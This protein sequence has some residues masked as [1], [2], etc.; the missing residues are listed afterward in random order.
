MDEK[1]KMMLGNLVG[2]ND[3]EIYVSSVEEAIRLLQLHMTPNGAKYRR[4]L[5]EYMT[6]EENE[7]FGECDVY[8]NF[9]M[10]LFRVGDYYLALLVCDFALELAPTNR[11][12]LADAI[13]ACRNSSQYERGEKYLSKAEE[14]DYSI[15][16]YRLFLYSIDFLQGKMNAFPSDMGIF[17][18]ADKLANEYIKKFPFDEHGY[19]QKAELLIMQNKR[20]EAIRLLYNYIIDLKPE[21]RE[22]SRLVCAQCCVTLLNL[23]DDSNNYELIINICNEGLKNSAQEQ[24]SARI[25]FFMYRKALAMD[26]MLHEKRFTGNPREVIDG[27]R[28]YQT[29]YDL[30][31][32]MT[33]KNTIE[34]RYTIL[35]SHADKYIPLIKRDLFVTDDTACKSEE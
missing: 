9:I 13:K 33:Y 3:E 10:D 16:T 29:A 14:L 24:P 4:K 22:G 31:Q 26:A 25:G 17:D 23:L 28:W 30:N 27:L 21:D 6:N 1:M 11:D 32:D 5:V 12:I 34:Q 35:M 15:W 19:N 2:E 18:R 8:H 7:V 20:A